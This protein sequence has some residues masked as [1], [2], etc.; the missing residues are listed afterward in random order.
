MESLIVELAKN[1]EIIKKLKD[2]P[3]DLRNHV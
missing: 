2:K 1:V 3:L